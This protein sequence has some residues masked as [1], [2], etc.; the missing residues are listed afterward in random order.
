MRTAY[1][2]LFVFVCTSC[3][4]SVSAPD[5]A[6]DGGA[7]TPSADASVLTDSGQPP[8]A[9]DAGAVDAQAPVGEDAGPPAQECLSDI[10]CPRGQYCLDSRCVDQCV[11]DSGCPEGNICSPNGRCLE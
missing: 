5:L 1:L 3:A 8:A 10:N 2:A 4:P 9:A 6:A 11:D 7:V